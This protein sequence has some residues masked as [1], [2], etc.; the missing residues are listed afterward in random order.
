M[1]ENN[2]D[3]L[4]T[5]KQAAGKMGVSRQTVYTWINSG[6]V[7]TVKTPGGRQRISERQLTFGVINNPERNE[8]DLFKIIDISNYESSRQ[9]TTGLKEKLWFSNKDGNWYWEI[10]GNEFLFKVGRPGT[11]ENWAEIVACKLAEL[12][13]L[14][15]A[16]YTLAI[17][18]GKEGV[19]T[20]SFVPSGTGL[21]LGNEILQYIVKEYKSEQ[22]YKQRKHTL[23][24]VIAAIAKY[25]EL[26]IQWKYIHGI[27]DAID[28]FIGYLMFDT[29]I[30][31]TDR[32]HENWGFIR[33]LS[34][35]RFHLAPTFDHASSLGSHENDDNRK[36][37]LTTKDLN[38][39]IHTYITKAR[40]ALYYKQTDNNPM[41]TIDA[42]KNASKFRGNSTQVWLDIL[43]NV[44]AKDVQ[45]I[46][47]KVPNEV[48]PN[49]SKEFTRNILEENR[50][51]L[52]DLRI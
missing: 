14:P 34:T 40:S 38:R 35:D 26:P 46:L 6:K 9:E 25:N 16:E 27:G 15:H 8:Q 12:I 50:R 28:V 31:N 10:G 44:T 48:M 19:I 1:L 24:R 29:W 47:N 33:D 51:R 37:R 20:P 17:Y 3:K 30:A 32:H 41:Y 2:M 23:S 42:F 5:I 43:N 52:L 7:K 4:L 22:R 21:I 11:G 13:S 49:I 18:R 45:S 36:E 39:Q